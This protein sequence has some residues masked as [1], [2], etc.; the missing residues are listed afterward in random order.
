MVATA[1]LST[2][3]VTCFIYLLVSWNNTLKWMESD[4]QYPEQINELYK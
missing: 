4:K 1:Y 2:Q 3:Y